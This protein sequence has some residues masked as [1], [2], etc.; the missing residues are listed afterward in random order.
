M[1]CIVGIVDKKT[2]KVLIGGDSSGISG[3][4]LTIRKDPKV[5]TNGSFVI[6]GTTSFRMLQLL[7]FSLKPPEIKTDDVYE[8]MCTDFINAVRNCFKD[9]GFL[10]KE[11]KGDEL[12]GW[13]L[14]GYK[15]RLFK[16][17]SDFQV[18]ENL[19]GMDSVGCGNSYALGS[20]YT[21]QKSDMEIKDRVIKSL[22]CASFFSCGVHKPF[23]V[24]TT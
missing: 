19:N 13:F 22:E 17:A 6:G 14:V 4:D 8:Y 24:V 20:L 2:K 23:I 12:G 16:I 5:F 18:T 15:N 3:W 10:Q 21:T 7:R 1:T 9:G 11:T